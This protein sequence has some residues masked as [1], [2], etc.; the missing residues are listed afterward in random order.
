VTELAAQR[1]RVLVVG[2]M[3]R[4]G[5]QI[6]EQVAGHAELCLGAALERGGHPDLGQSIEADVVLVDDVKLALGASDVVID[7]S[8]PV[9]TLANLHAAADAGVAY[10]T[11]TTGFSA[12]ER[13]EI[14]ALAE[15]IPVIHAPN[16]S[17]A[18]NVLGWLAEQASARLGRDFDAELFEIHHSMKRDAP[19]GTALFL[20]EAV[21]RGR[22]QNLDDHL[23]LE[24]A[25]EIGARSEAE[26][27]IQ[28]LRGGDNPGEHTVMFVGKGERV[29]LVHRS[30]T[31]EHFASGAV[32][33]A[34]WLIGREPGLYPIEQVFGL[35]R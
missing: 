30:A 2:A 26:I 33:A 35:D 6:R 1:K 17:L 4:M 25:G 9:S 3:G 22:E 20:A 27:G 7:F 8:T 24:R 16:F 15:R 23:V 28:T 11:G 14:A 34:A 18:V 32:R 10:V 5:E 29:E 12:E 13:A 31:R 19:S 21:A